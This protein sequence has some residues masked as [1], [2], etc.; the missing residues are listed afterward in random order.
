MSCN[1]TRQHYERFFLRFFLLNLNIY[2]NFKIQSIIVV[3]LLIM[4]FISNKL[5]F[6]EILINQ[7]NR[8]IYFLAKI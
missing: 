1:R 7:Y 5:Y 4:L 8:I 2:R 3:S 6:I